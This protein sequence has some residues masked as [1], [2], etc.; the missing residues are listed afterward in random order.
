[1]TSLG[2]FPATNGQLL[3]DCFDDTFSTQTVDSSV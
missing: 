2:I 3:T 1:M